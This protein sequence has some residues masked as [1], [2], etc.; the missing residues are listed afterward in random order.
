LDAGTRVIL[1]SRGELRLE[2]G[3]VY[4]DSDGADPARAPLEVVTA[5]GRVREIGTRYEVRVG[6][7]AWSV[8]VRDGR[9][10]VETGTGTH[11]VDAGARLE[12]GADGATLGT[13]SDREPPG[14]DWL[15]EIAPTLDIE[16]RSLQAFLAWVARETG[17]RVRFA[18]EALAAEATRIRL[19][20]TIEGLRPDQAVEVVLP[21]AGLAHRVEDGELRIER[22]LRTRP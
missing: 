20:G 13:G 10:A 11:E 18:D 22:A 1:V 4:V 8:R 16:G 9:L 7:A 5:H 21:G 3:A 19:H 15:L 17:W 12:L 14:W 2:R 6:A